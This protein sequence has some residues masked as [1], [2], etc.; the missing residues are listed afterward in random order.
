MARL[1]TSTSFRSLSKSFSRCASRERMTVGPAAGLLA[2]GSA[3]A[4]AAV[5]ARAG[6]GAGGLAR[7]PLGAPALGAAAGVPAGAARPPPLD[8]GAVSGG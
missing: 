4:G 6:A 2:L 8:G 1:T 3:A 7:L 5:G